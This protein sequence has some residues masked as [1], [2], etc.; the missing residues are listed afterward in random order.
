MTGELMSESSAFR[1]ESVSP[2]S[3]R[4]PVTHSGWR[5]RYHMQT[6]AG[7]RMALPHERRR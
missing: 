6:P 4:C 5:L 3:F 2:L 1:D 7:R